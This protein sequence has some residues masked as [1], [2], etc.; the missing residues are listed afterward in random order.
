[1][2]QHDTAHTDLALYLVRAGVLGSYQ[3]VGSVMSTGRVWDWRS[4]DDSR[5]AHRAGA[6]LRRKEDISH[7]K[8]APKEA[9]A[10]MPVWMSPCHVFEADLV[11]FSLSWNSFPEDILLETARYLRDS[12]V[13]TL[14]ASCQHYHRALVPVLY[15]AIDID[16]P[17]SAY[18]P[19]DA[20][21]P[22]R[23]LVCLLHSIRYRS[24]HPTIPANAWFIQSLTYISY[25]AIVDLRTIP[26]LAVI[27]FEFVVNHFRRCSLARTSPSTILRA[28][29]PEAATLLSLPRL[30]SVRSTKL[31]IV[32]A[33][34][35]HRPV[36]TAV[37]D[38]GNTIGDLK[39]LLPHSMPMTQH[40]LTRLSLS[41]LGQS[42]RF[43]IIISAIAI[44]F[45]YLQH[46]A[47]RTPIRFS[48]NL[49]KSLLISLEDDIHLLL[50]VQVVSVN[51]AARREGHATTLEVFIPDIVR[52]GAARHD[53]V[54]I[55]YGR[56]MVSRDM[57]DKP[58]TF[59]TDTAPERFP[60]LMRRLPQWP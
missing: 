43:R 15:R 39:P 23:I 40:S 17:V 26:M 4:C 51:H 6:R 7:M 38:Y 8:I 24:S 10:V 12:D 47:L 34:M 54:Q 53:L 57:R 58:W 52:L 28:Y 11:A 50:G 44:T 20:N 49:L 56:A 21:H 30:E 9:R 16:I 60:W 27:L 48:A 32:V 35:Q 19:V 13:C 37:V 3:F 41:I 29:S 18:P 42:L 45:P 46:L 31:D 1:M 2:T 14:L 5:N 33:L 55:G 25:D 22:I 36:R 59:I